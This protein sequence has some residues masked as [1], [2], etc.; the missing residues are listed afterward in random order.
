[1]YSLIYK[2]VK[3]KEIPVGG[4]KKFAGKTIKA[5]DS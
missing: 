3:I 2:V 5:D 4:M 1:M